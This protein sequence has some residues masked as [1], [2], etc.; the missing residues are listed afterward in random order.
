M[1]PALSCSSR[2]EPEHLAAEQPLTE[3]FND[4]G[5]RFVLVG[6]AS[7][8]DE[9]AQRRR[10]QSREERGRPT[11]E[12]LAEELRPRMLLDGHEYVGAEPAFELA[13]LIL[14]NVPAEETDGHDPGANVLA[15]VVQAI[16]PAADKIFGDEDRIRITWPGPWQ[17]WPYTTAV[18][19][20]CTGTMIGPSTLITAAHCVHTGRSWK[21]LRP[22][23]PFKDG[24]REPIG[25]FFCY[26]VTVPDGWIAWGG[27]DHYD[28]AVVEFGYCGDENKIRFDWGMDYFGYATGWVGMKTAP[29][30]M[31]NLH[32]FV[33]YPWQDTMPRGETGYPAP[34]LGIG[35]AGRRMDEFLYYKMDSY[36]GDSGAG[37][38]RSETGGTWDPSRDKLVGTVIGTNWYNGLNWG[39]AVDSGVISFVRANSAL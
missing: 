4:K 18:F 33:G 1:L 12:Q 5:S 26:T 34:Y 17:Q 27:D 19:T 11:R 28:Y 10:D 32:A 14:S 6:P 20:H 16:D 25:R 13:D 30:D 39:R 7:F 15:R 36:D 3:V 21:T 22:Y 23:I 29:D 24:P 31:D 9:P 8:S 2:T 38:I 37:L 35:T